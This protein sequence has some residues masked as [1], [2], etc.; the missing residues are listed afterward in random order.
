MA[1]AHEEAGRA[2]E[3]LRELIHGIHPKVLADHGLAAAV[4]DAADRSAVPVDVS[5]ELPGRLPRA[6]EAAAYFVVC[7][8]LANVAKHS[9][10]DRAEVTGGH[11][12]GRLRL[13]IRDNGRGG[14]EDR[15]RVGAAEPGAGA[16]VDAESRA[17]SGL[18]GLAD[19]VS[20]LD[21]R[22]SLS[23]PPGGPTLLRVEIP[24]EWTTEPFA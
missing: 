22:I 18:T 19:R 15:A 1:K 14:A 17:G 20:V 10:A 16:D 2:L 12:G 11:H 21:G 7:E 8:A 13:E 4:D 3:E 5:L 6:V 9:G 24:C 23:S